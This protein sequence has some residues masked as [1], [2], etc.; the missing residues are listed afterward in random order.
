MNVHTI[1]SR[2]NK[3]PYVH[4]Y[5][6]IITEL[7]LE[8]QV[9]EYHT[10]SVLVKKLLF[11]DTYIFACTEYGSK[12]IITSTDLHGKQIFRN[13]FSDQSIKADNIRMV[14]RSLQLTETND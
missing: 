5:V 6:I 12:I 10:C 2:N 1:V 4:T 8:S 7:N 11:L 13:P 3:R 9:R 14:E